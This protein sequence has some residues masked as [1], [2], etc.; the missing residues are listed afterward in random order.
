MFLHIL[1]EP[2]DLLLRKIT[3]A[4]PVPNTYLAGSTALALILRH[5]ESVDFA[6]LSAAIFNVEVAAASPA[7][8][9]QL[10][11]SETKRGNFHGFIDAVQVTWLYCPNPCYA[12]PP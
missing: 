7:K 6:W 10:R 3:A 2:R 1:G 8:I 4:P 9:G 12:S 11:I 5:R